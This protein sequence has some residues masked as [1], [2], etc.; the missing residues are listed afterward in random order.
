LLLIY[1]TLIC[2]IPITGFAQNSCC[3]ILINGDF[4]LGNTGFTSNLPQNCQCLANSYCVGSNFQDKCP[5]WQNVVGHGGSGQFLIVDG[6]SNS[7]VDVWQNTVI[8]SNA[9]EY[10]F[11]F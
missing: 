5:G 8:I 2:I 9:G 6:N 11:S 4:E 10:C 7:A 3:N 1:V